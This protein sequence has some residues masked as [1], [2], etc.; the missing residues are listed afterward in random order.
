MDYFGMYHIKMN[1]KG[2]SA[3]ATRHIQSTVHMPERKNCPC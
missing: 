2:N 1:K 3:T